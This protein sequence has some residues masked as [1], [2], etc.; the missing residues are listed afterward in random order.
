MRPSSC[1][2]KGRRLQQ[3]V[4]TWILDRFTGLDPD[5]VNSRS[6]GASG[7]DIMLSQKARKR[8]PFSLECKS[9]ERLNVYKAYQQAVA[10]SG[11]Y[12][13]AAVIKSNH[14][15]PLIV[16]DAEWFINNWNQK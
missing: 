7:E 2:N 9:T 11:D 13:P 1:K 10:N 16:L 15:K 12:Q 14:K 6:M 4:V 3:Q 8:F 5:D